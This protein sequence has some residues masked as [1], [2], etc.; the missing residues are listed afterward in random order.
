MIHFSAVGGENLFTRN[1]SIAGQVPEN[2]DGDWLNHGGDWLWP[3][4]Q[5]QWADIGSG[6][7]PPPPVMEGSDWVGSGWREE[8]GTGVIE[9]RRI[10]GEPVF[11]E[12]VR[13]FRLPPGAVPELQVVQSVRRI[14]ASDVPVTLWHISQIHEADEVMLGVAENSRFDQGFRHIAFEPLKSDLMTSCPHGVSYLPL[15]GGEHKAG[16]DARWIAARK[17]SALLM[18]W[19]EGGWTGGELPDEGCGV[20]FY[21]NA[22]LGY[23]EIETQSA[24]VALAPGETLSN[25]VVYRLLETDPD[26]DPCERAKRLAGMAP[27]SG[28]VRFSP[29]SAT[30]GDSIE[31][32]VLNSLGNG[33]LHWGVN[34]P[35]GDW[36]LPAEAYWPE[37]STPADS[38]VAVNTPLPPPV[39]GVSTLRLGPFDRPE[40]VVRSL[41]AAVRWGDTWDSNDG[42]NYNVS[43]SAHPDASDILWS[44]PSAET[45]SGKLLLGLE[46]TPDADRLRLMLDGEEV[47]AADGRGLT[48]VLETSDWEYG[49]HTFTA[50]AVRNDHLSVSTRQFWKLPDLEPGPDLSVDYPYGAIQEDGTIRLHLLAPN[51]RFVEVEWRTGQE[52]GRSLMQTLEGGRWT[53]SLSADPQETLMYRYVMDGANRF[54]DPWSKQVDWVNP[55]TGKESHLPEHA[56]TVV[57]GLPEALPAWTPPKP[58]TW[59]IYELS[60][61]D[62]APPGSYAGLE[63]K[64]EYIRD[65]GVNAIE[66]LPVT[67][68]PGSESWGYNPA[69]HMAPEGAYGTPEELASLI[70]AARSLGIAYVKDIVLNHVDGSGPLHAMHGPAE[71]NPYT[72]VFNSFNWGFPKLDQE[73]PA[74]KRYVKDT[75]THWV[76]FW[77]VDGYRYDATQWIKWSGYNDWGASWMSYV[78]DQ[79]NP[80]VFQMAENLPSEPAMVKGTELD[81]EWDGHYRWRMRRVF[82]R[83]Q[84]EEPEKFREILD[85][86][87]HAYQSGWQRVPYIESHDEER[88]MRELLQAGY[89][90]EDALRRHHAAAAVTLTVPGVPMLY[91]GQEWGESTKKVVGLNPLQWEVAE[92]PARAELR[93]AF[94]ELI[95]LRTGH[96]ALHHD[97][98]EILELDATTGTVVYLRPGVP[99]SV[100]VAF[101]VSAEPVELDLS[102]TG[103]LVR[104]LHRE[105]TA[106]LTNVHLRAG[107][108]RI[109]V[110]K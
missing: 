107:E 7:W 86:R 27:Q 85:P 91:A 52:E 20:V 42:E 110:V 14:N 54:A 76:T 18:Q 57:G 31:V 102:D 104:E 25:T 12:V 55:V 36:A 59:V 23:T 13:Q 106:D 53:L 72:M 89:S 103:T 24:E 33:M 63:S 69:F 47:A 5:G 11:V 75:L 109:F 58:E 19:T 105:K 62:V 90:G 66:P 8:D 21:A 37:G 1:E 44:A 46:T 4:H 26:A 61:P 60:I 34:G 95:Q 79:A 10:V 43:F 82:S 83:G 99:E 49:P 38:G 64:L 65:L 80:G 88:F 29:S 48:T 101:N 35:D 94:R 92:Q 9:L 71:V 84:I 16:S 6:D 2:A 73:S 17:G 32:S 96:R 70:R 45:L 22:G 15:E 39:D 51:A 50:I 93:E 28:T 77:G 56:W 74:F 81:G 98:I 68:F 97:K 30:F 41:H 67:A 108:A 87:S 78:V 100:L 40:Q 3:V